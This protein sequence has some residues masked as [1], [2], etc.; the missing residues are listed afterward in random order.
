[1]QAYRRS[2]YKDAKVFLN[3][4]LKSYAVG[5]LEK[6]HQVSSAGDQFL[7]GRRL[8]EREIYGWRNLYGDDTSNYRCHGLL[9]VYNHDGDYDGDFEKFFEFMDSKRSAP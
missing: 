6:K 7:Q 4:D 5:S 3:V 9:F 2:R 1:M 8:C